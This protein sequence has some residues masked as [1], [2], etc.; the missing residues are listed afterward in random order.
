MDEIKDIVSRVVDQIVNKQKTGQPDLMR[1]WQRA[2]GEKEYKHT[3]V[4]GMNNG[5]LL[6]DVDCSA[7]MF[8]CRLKYRSILKSVQAEVPEIKKIFFKIGKIQ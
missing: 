4:V 1:V 7:W 5:T 8:Q 2:A 6:V 3:R